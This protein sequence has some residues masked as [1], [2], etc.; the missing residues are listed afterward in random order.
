MALSPPLAIGRKGCKAQRWE[1]RRDLLF[2]GS[3]CSAR[4]TDIVD[5]QRVGGVQPVEV[6]E[7]TKTDDGSADLQA[8]ERC[9]KSAGVRH[10][11]YYVEGVTNFVCWAIMFRGGHHGTTDTTQD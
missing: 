8:E 11:D 6:E 9:G 3:D 7:L 4:V 10:G 2:R 1:T 5:D